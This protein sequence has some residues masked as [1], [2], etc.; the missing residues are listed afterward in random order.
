MTFLYRLALALAP[1]VLFGIYSLHPGLVWLNLVV[2]VPWA[3]LYT[4]DRA[5]RVS[6]AWYSLGA[7]ASWM[8][9][10]HTA[11]RFGWFVPPAAAVVL[12]FFWH[13]FGVL[14]R[15]VHHRLHL[16]RSLTVAVFW[17]AVEWLRV[18][19]T[20]ANFDI[21]QVG[22]A[23]APFR[24]LVQIAD[25]TGV[26]GVSFLVAAVNGWIADAWFAARDG[27]GIRAALRAR[28]VR[29]GA[30]ALAAA[31]VAAWG[32]GA[33]RLATVTV[34]EGPR[35]GLIQPNLPH[36]KR[37]V[38]GVH[39][40]QA[41]MTLEGI[42][43]GSVDMIVW[44]E[45]AILYVLP[46][47]PDYLADLAWLATVK[48]APIL[49]GAQGPVDGAPALATNSA[50]L[51]ERDG[52]VQGRYDKQAMF[53]WSEVLPGD[54][55]FMR[56]VPR[57]GRLQRLMARVG[58][59][60]QANGVAGT[61]TTVFDLPW[62]GERVPF[63]TLIC[64]ENTN[65]SLP[66]DAGRLGARFFVNITNEGSVGGPT[67]EQLLRT[68]MFRAIENRMGY[69]RLG[70]TGISGMIDPTGNLTELLRG[71]G[72]QVINV[73]GIL[74]ARVP[75]APGAVAP[76][77]RTHDAFVKLVLAAAL[78]LLGA[79][80]VRR[81]SA[82]AAAVAVAIVA[83]T[84][85]SDPAALGTDPARA[86]AALA[87]G[88]QALE[89]GRA[90]EAIS[91][92]REACAGEDACR[93]ALPLLARAYEATPFDDDAVLAFGAI[94][95]RFPALAPTALAHRGAFLEN[96]LDTAGAE[97]AYRASLAAAPDPIVRGRLAL[98]LLRSDRPGEA[99]A[100]VE[101]GLAR[102]P[103]HAG[104]RVL[105]ARARRESGDLDGARG[106]LESLTSDPRSA[107]I[108]PVWVEYGRVLAAL[109]DLAGADDAWN[110]ALRVDPGNLA[111]RFHLARYALRA[112]D[113]EAAATWIAEMQ[114]LDGTVVGP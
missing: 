93:E 27:G 72:G 5:P 17:V 111:A 56:W 22:Y 12:G 42:E 41:R 76:Y 9:L 103:D 108:A 34:V 107:G 31:V 63:A 4:D 60:S 104:L 35:L 64:V 20:L 23:M 106:V 98:L 43:P 11:L 73:E 113:G 97:A 78:G 19:F 86:G 110:R 100:E 95:E 10:H 105:L 13:P 66:A 7:W 3:I 36:S 112:G 92:L 14:L 21:Y 50:Y 46:R 84:G 99:L 53:P 85:C 91:P 52:S 33:Y 8:T 70:N 57:I 114:R 90:G 16:P 58:W 26:Y 38:M 69:V 18:T 28:A 1:P 87:R 48:D 75:L 39:L 94:A 79:T 49:V 77:P 51:V 109:G 96:T 45:S 88:R 101:A 74:V 30:I 65:P 55:L 2:L 68:A 15:R 44:P 102:D 29:G 82:R 40:E 37:N 24:A 61:R 6:W 71:A 47:D 67:Q 62:N 54:R 83:V 80:F 32:Y 81:P 59:G 89:S 25:L